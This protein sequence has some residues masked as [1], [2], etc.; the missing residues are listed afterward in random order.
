M[1]RIS[2]NEYKA[3]RDEMNMRI[4]LMNTHNLGMI[5]AVFAVWA[6]VGVLL[7]DYVQIF[8]QCATS[9]I[10]IAIILYTLLIPSL[11]IIPIAIITPLAV[12]SGDN[13]GQIMSLSTYIRLYAELPSYLDNDTEFIGWESLQKKAIEHKLSDKFLNSEYLI[14][15]IISVCMFIAVSA[16]MC[17]YGIAAGFKDL[18]YI[19]PILTALAILGIVATKFIARKS[20][21]RMFLRRR[22]EY[23]KHY[24][25]F[26]VHSGTITQEDIDNYN[27]YIEGNRIN[28]DNNI[29]KRL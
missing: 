1:K 8:S 7:K 20:S 13:L 15:S 21:T 17:G 10:R 9:N 16:I 24:C 4:Q 25:D 18:L 12:K 2:V 29:T 19:I 26:A 3:L 23:Y 6:I 27:N 5:T 28:K 22:D 14:L 11:I